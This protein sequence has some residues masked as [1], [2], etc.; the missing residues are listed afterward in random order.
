MADDDTEYV[1]SD[2]DGPSS[3]ARPRGGGGGAGGGATTTRCV[4]LRVPIFPRTSSSA[5]AAPIPPEIH[6]NLLPR[7]PLYVIST[8][9]AAPPV[10]LTAAFPPSGFRA[11]APEDVRSE[12]ARLVAEVSSVLEMP[13]ECASLLLLHHRWSK[14]A[15]FDAYYASPVEARR[16]AGITH[17]G[18]SS[19]A[20]SP[21]MCEICLED[22]TAGE[23]FALGCKH[24]FCRTCWAGFCSAAVNDQGTNCVNTRCPAGCGEA[25]PFSVV[26][27]FAPP[28]I[29]ARWRAYELK[30]FVGVSK[31]MA[32]CPA[33]GCETAFVARSS[34]RIIKCPCGMS[35]CFKCSK[36][37]HAPVEC[38]TIE[39]WLAKCGNESETANWMLL[40][41]KK[42]PK[43]TVRIEKNQGCNHI[44][45]SNKG[46]RHEFCWTCSGPWVEHGQTT[47]GYYKC[48]KFTAR[49]EAADGKTDDA[50]RAKVRACAGARGPVT[51]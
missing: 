13:G 9:S 21:F 24:I 11:L 43:C 37:A 31:T 16:A 49:T 32:V 1:Y 41:T 5:R 10:F 18:V 4:E 23:G 19:R 6:P 33:P 20:T 25:V 35:F 8:P 38:P 28:A 30:H 39:S 12:Q 26:H 3:P 7:A 42:C 50:S 27:A 47:G 46:C 15:L 34:V 40:N 2:D 29:V 51:H 22:R 45:C 17:L 36:E 48:N 44:K 14:E